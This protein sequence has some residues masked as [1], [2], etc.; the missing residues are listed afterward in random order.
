MSFRAR[1][2]LF[3]VAYWA[4]AELSY[5]LLSKT[6]EFVAFWPPAGLCLAILLATPRRRWWAALLAAGV[7]NFLSDVVVHQHG[8]PASFGFLLVNLGAPLVG[9]AL[10]TRLCR[11]A[12]TFARL[13][14][15]LAWSALA[16]LVSTP[17][18][19]LF[20][21]AVNQAFY[22]G[23]FGQKMLFWWIGDLLGVLLLTPL[24]YGVL[25][26]R[27]WPRL[28]EAC[29]MIALLLSLSA[30]TVLI[31]HQPNTF[32]LPPA[33]LFF[34][35]LWAA[36]RFGATAV[37]A[38]TS[39]LAF[40]ALWLTALGFGPYSLQIAMSARLLMTQMMVVTGALLF[41][42]LAAVMAE[43]R[44]A[45]SELQT[46]NLRL[47]QQVQART[48][49]LTTANQQLRISEERLQ[50]GVQVA[51]FAI[52]EIDYTNNTN[53]LS[54]A[55]AQLYGLGNEEI[56]V[57]REAVHATFHPGDAKDLAPLIAASLNPDGDG[58]FVREHRIVW[59]NGDV[60]WLSVRKQIFFDRTKNPARPV[61]GILAAQD[62]TERKRQEEQ[63][64]LALN[65]N[66]VA[67]EA[68]RAMLY[69]YLP[70]TDKVI[71]NDSFASVVGYAADEIPL[72]GTMWK[73]LIHPDDVKEAW[74]TIGAGIASGA[75]FSVEYRVRHKDGHYIWVFDRARVLRDES[76]T[77][78]RVIGMFLNISER[79]AAD[80]KLRASEEFNRTVLESSP[81]CVKILDS[82][83]RLEYMNANGL[84]LLEIDD[85][86][87]FKNEFWWNL[88]QEETKPVIKESLAKALR[89][90]TAEFEA[91]CLTIKG[92][93][94]WWNVIVSPVTGADGK[95][96]RL[97]SV[98]RDITDR[99]QAE[100]NL[101]FLDEISEDLIRLSAAGE[102]MQVTAAKIGSY[103]GVTN[104]A[105]I[106]VDTA[107]NRSVVY[108]VWRTDEAAV[109][110]ARSYNLSEFLTDDIRQIFQAGKPLVVND[111][112][113]DA[114]TA[115]YAANYQPLQIGSLINAPF[116]GEGDLKFVLGVY[117]RESYEWRTDEI[118]LLGELITRVG[119]RIERSRT[120]EKLQLS[121][122]RFRR[123]FESAKDGILILNPDTAQIIDANPY[124]AGLLGYSPAELTGKEL[125][126]IGLFKDI[127]KSQAAMR[128]LQAKKYIRYED[129]PLETKTGRRA[130]MEFVSNVYVEGNETIIQCNIRDITERQV[131][132]QRLR[133]EEERFRLL[134]ENA[135]D[136]AIVFIDKE[137]RITHW[138]K[139]AER[140]L[141]WPEKEIIGQSVALIFTPEDQTNKIPE[142]EIAIAK[143]KGQAR[144]ERWHLRKDG[145]R[146]YGF[147]EMIALRDEA[148]NLRGFV[149]LF[150]DLT[151]RKEAENRLHES[152]ERFRA[153]FDSI[154]E[155][156]CI[157]EMIFDEYNKPLDYRFVQ[158][159]PAMEQLTGLKDTLGK[160][161][162]ELVPELEEFWF[163]TYGKVALT[164]EAVRFENHSEPMNRWFEVFASRVGDST[165]RVAIVFN[166][167]TERKEIEV[168][169]EQLLQEEQR[170]R[171]AAEAATCAK[172]EFLAVVSHELRNPLNS[173]LGYA[174]LLRTMPTIDSAQIKKTVDIIE[175]SGK[176]QLELI[177]DLLDTARVISGKLKLEI[178][179]IDLSLLINDAVEVMRPA[180][181]AK[182]IGLLQQFDPGVGQIVG[183]PQRLQ[184]VIWNLL[185]NA[186]KFTPPGG[187]I[188]ITLRRAEAGIAIQV[189][190]NGKGLSPDFLPRIFERFTQA[191]ASETR[192]HGGL[193]L[194][195]SLVKQ[196]VELHG[197][198][199]TVESEGEGKGATFT[200]TLPVQSAYNSVEEVRQSLTLSE[201]DR[202]MFSGLAILVIDD[203]SEARELMTTLLHDYG[204]DVTA[205]A[206]AAEGFALLTDET[207]EFSILISDIG[208]P[209][210][211]GYSLMGRLREW[212]SSR[213]QRL[214]AIAITSFGRTEDRMAAMMAGFHMH[215]PKPVETEEL[216]AVI[217]SLLGRFN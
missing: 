121:E 143:E 24:T 97:I 142:K 203:D 15:V 29:E 19:A 64:Q 156:F 10:I 62:I 52:C 3:A 176:A 110:F 132:E 154:D 148:G 155:G 172:D 198:E 46:S 217:N 119:I 56:T 69:E 43:R 126:E 170:A 86:A 164:G 145:S 192:R 140:I 14:H 158:A 67:Q 54:P 90:E 53:H 79:K 175:R 107:A 213:K 181:D 80:E 123:L 33:V 63:L 169:R 38:A 47:D 25:T 28:A 108:P 151:E 39:V 216:I 146:F 120:E 95:I 111:I 92:T 99:K 71:R 211:D 93:P 152:E 161:A 87:P 208:M 168:R 196:L 149:K 8:L 36:L 48:T 138:N 77:V 105:F 112:M 75:G 7:P 61:H 191:D 30:T 209:E 131:A 73:S 17:L 66:E 162:R 70:Q 26:W 84:C 94:K 184:Q 206:S 182:N 190:D 40:I 102:I 96:S 104:C 195:L 118:E 85:F 103:F 4:G 134:T 177:N 194:G 60:R 125:W 200:I 35:L 197:G 1:L 157:I 49:E 163:A 2:I 215:V 113:T 109:D 37:A 185:S 12:F 16:S 180:A 171:E 50:L 89:G 65:R 76:G 81:D 165:S 144:D 147:G 199:I 88:W 114:L 83:G 188:G 11:P 57:P 72:T 58:G 136:Y 5:L 205:V 115:P 187:V 166:N 59:P 174:R 74:E 128:E 173:I 117:R 98:S 189:R 41:Y 101:A 27:Q 32:S 55:A 179:P 18:G 45:E 20:G 210:E 133:D 100:L 122:E 34:F 204:A 22:G 153:I 106:E 160:T 183:D 193:G 214:P 167:I 68:A 201:S 135:K 129:L 127:E 82:D 186:V 31:F 51:D 141:G 137:M 159:N 78:K 44:A 9:A 202:Q 42:I 91:F 150:R 130:Y 21:A 116:I 139:G 178:V 207:T 6:G 23:A 212:E 124:I 13:S